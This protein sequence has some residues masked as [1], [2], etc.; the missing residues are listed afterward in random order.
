MLP[1]SFRRNLHL[2]AFPLSRSLSHYD[3]NYHK[4]RRAATTLLL[5]AETCLNTKK[6][7]HE[8]LY[9]V[10][11]TKGARVKWYIIRFSFIFATKSDSSKKR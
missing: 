1:T 8:G 4:G 2:Y 5:R 6:I 10:S 3:Y 9:S 11:S 7:D